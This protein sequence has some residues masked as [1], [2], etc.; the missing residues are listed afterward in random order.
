MKKIILVLLIGVFLFVGYHQVFAYEDFEWYEK[1]GN[2]KL[3]GE[4]TDEDYLQAYEKVQK[5]F[6]GWSYYEINHRIKIK[7]I[8]KTLYDYYNNGKSPIKFEYSSKSQTIDEYSLKATGSI[9]VQ[10]QKGTK[11]FGDGLNAQVSATY[12]RTE[13][14]KQD[15]E[16]NVS[17]SVEPGTQLLVYM[18]GEGYVANGV[19]KKYFFNM[20][21]AKGGYE[22]FVMVSHYQRVEVTPI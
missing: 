13:K 3:I 1:V 10:T 16:I 6:I 17:T 9:K 7:F 12:E 19:A 22:A 15:E 18:Y 8:S 4:F 11:I 14:L 5:K 2:N 20:E 21:R